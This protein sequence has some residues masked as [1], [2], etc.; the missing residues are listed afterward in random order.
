V[1]HANEMKTARSYSP[2]AR[3]RW[4]ELRD[5]EGFEMSVE[6]I[7]PTMNC[8]GDTK[9]APWHFSQETDDPHH[10]DLGQAREKEAMVACMPILLRFRET[11]QIAN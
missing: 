2:K 10:P 5:S 1:L 4:P 6:S 7:T 9:R 8:Q 3:A 11:E